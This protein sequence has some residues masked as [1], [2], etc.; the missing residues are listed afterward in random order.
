MI[1]INVE[2]CIQYSLYIKV[3]LQRHFLYMALI[4]SYVMVRGKLLHFSI[5]LVT[6]S[7]LWWT[8]GELNHSSL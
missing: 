1:D 7:L 6:P 2:K 8:Q 3:N 5:V 4:D